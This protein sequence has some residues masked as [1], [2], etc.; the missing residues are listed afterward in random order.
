MNDKKAIILYSGVS[1][2][3]APRIASL[4]RYLVENNYDIKLGGVVKVNDVDDAFDN[5]LIFEFGG[6]NIFRKVL[7]A[8]IAS[9]NLFFSL[10]REDFNNTIVYA[11]NPISGLV[12]YIISKLK[13]INYIY[14]TQ[15]IFIGTN[16]N[17]FSG[18]W[19]SIWYFLEKKIAKSSSK[20]ITN[21]Q[22]RMRFLR[23]LYSLEQDKCDF[24]Y[25]A[26]YHSDYCRKSLR[27]KYG[28]SSKEIIYSYCGVINKNRAVL[29]IISAFNKSNVPNS[30]LLLV[31]YYDERFK[32]MLDS[33][34]IANNIANIFF[35]GKVSNN[36]L[37]E[38]M[39]L[40]DYTFALYSNDCL[41]NR[42]NSPNKL[43]DAINCKVSLITNKTPLAS[44]LNKFFP[45]VLIN[46][47]SESA[48]I[49]AINKTRSVTIKKESNAM[50]E[51]F[52]MNYILPNFI[53]RVFN[54]V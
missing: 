46:E 51:Q 47:N 38:Y 20:F 50:L 23:R 22:F 39:A 17:F 32:D 6:N 12:I 48:I 36:I 21:D 52:T 53:K 16:H 5:S 30:K 9:V 18:K 4:A 31:G 10:L 33:Y 43:F 35:T 40:S 27:D 54:E 1:I 28:L 3:C 37:K 45:S 26:P 34:I 24:I 13:K 19:R 7:S 2:D 41:N 15:E 49:D 44:Y 14:E 42:L 8:I 25:N 11:V 29:E